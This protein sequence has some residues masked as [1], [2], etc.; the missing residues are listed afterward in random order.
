MKLT[1]TRQSKTEHSI[2]S[3]EMMKRFTK[4]VVSMYSEHG[5]IFENYNYKD[6]NFSIFET[7]HYK[8][9]N[10]LKDQNDNY[11]CQY[12]NNV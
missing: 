8:F 5:I 2:I 6:V 4:P 3:L 1:T 11:V 12:I 10:I 9:Y 7:Q